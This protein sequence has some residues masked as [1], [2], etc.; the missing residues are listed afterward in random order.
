MST[1]PSNRCKSGC[2]GAESS[3]GRTLGAHGISYIL[4]ED[5]WGNGYATEAAKHVVA[6]AFTTARLERLEAMHH[7]DDPASGVS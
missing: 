6:F 3:T 1:G 7:P 2:Y 4:R 5:A